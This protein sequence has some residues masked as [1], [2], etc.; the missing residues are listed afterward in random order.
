MRFT[1]LF[2]HKTSKQLLPFI[3]INPAVL[4]IPN[5]ILDIA[6]DEVVADTP[7]SN[8]VTVTYR[9]KVLGVAQAFKGN[10]SGVYPTEN[11]TLILDEV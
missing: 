5:V 2:E 11:A 3:D 10:H 1:L 6:M 4:S 9:F 7:F 8:P